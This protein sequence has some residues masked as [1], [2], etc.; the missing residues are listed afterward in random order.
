[1]NTK[2]AFPVAQG[3]SKK[4]A[5]KT[6]NSDTNA[7]VVANL[8]MVSSVL[9]MT[10]SG[11]PTVQA[12]RPQHSLPCSTGAAEKPSI[13]ACAKQYYP[14]RAQKANIIMDTTYFERSFGVMVLMDSISK[15]AL[16]C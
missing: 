4:T 3:G 6:A 16:F 5:G 15:Q 12:N 1:M 9:I 11:Q 8:L 14:C 7:T 10:N 13:A 2:N